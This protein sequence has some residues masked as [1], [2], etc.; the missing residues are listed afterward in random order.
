M[1]K[2]YF[3]STLMPITPEKIETKI[4]NKNKTYTL[5]NSS[6][7][8]ILKDPGLTD[9]SFDLLLPNLQYPFALY[10]N[11]FQ[12]A[13]YYLDIF[14]RYKLDKTIFRLIVDRKLSVKNDFAYTS[15]LVSLEDYTIKEDVKYGFDFM[16]SL[17]LKQYIHKTTTSVILP[18]EMDSSG[19]AISY[20]SSSTRADTT[21]NSPSNK[22]NIP[23]PYRV[24]EG[25]Y[26]FNIC[27]KFLGDGN[28]CW[29]I[30]KYNNI[31]NPNVIV[32]GMSIYFPS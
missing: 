18:A 32:P 16:V 20:T 6:E 8:N 10:E 1:Y 17:K 22:S 15:I 25:D 31:A 23:S 5:L 24:V 28:R 14:E 3:G 7:I 21:G 9:I 30:A 27:K 12:K 2:L 19:V 29:E 26:L 4:N 13:K 11:G